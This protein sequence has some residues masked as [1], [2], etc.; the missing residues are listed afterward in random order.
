MYPRE[1]EAAALYETTDV[2]AL[3]DILERYRV[4]YIYVGQLERHVY[5]GPGLAKFEELARV[6]T[7]SRV[8]HNDKVDIYEVLRD[9]DA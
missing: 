3:F 7:L 6:G 5:D 2:D 9:W 8:F 4:K 1:R